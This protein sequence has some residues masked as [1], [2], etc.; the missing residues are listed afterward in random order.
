[1]R[2]SVDTNILISYLLAPLS[3]NPPSRIVRAAFR[4]EFSL[5]IVDTT[6]AELEDKVRRKRFLVERLSPETVGEL[7]ALLRTIADVH[8]LPSSPLPRVVRDPRDDYLLV[9]AVL[10]RV[11]F[12]VSGDRDLLALGEL[13]GVRM[14]SPVDFARILD[15]QNAV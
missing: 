7:I 2:A 13:Q 12:V 9:P 5:V 4:G 6:L 14:V 8:P 1:M 3:D 11:D 15:A 10:E